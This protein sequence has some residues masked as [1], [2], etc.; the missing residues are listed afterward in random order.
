MEHIGLLLHSHVNIG[1]VLSLLTFH[2]P[3]V[4]R[5]SWSVNMT[6]DEDKCLVRLS[7]HT[8]QL[9]CVR[10]IPK[11]IYIYLKRLAIHV[12]IFIEKNN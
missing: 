11:H 9:F 5:E 1:D 6:H 4:H 3:I 7:S 2:A 10:I 12:I 8:T